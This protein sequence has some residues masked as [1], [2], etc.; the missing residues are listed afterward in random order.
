MDALRCWRSC[1]LFCGLAAVTQPLPGLAQSGSDEPEKSLPQTIEE[2][3]GQGDFDFE[4]GSWKTRVSVLRHPLSGSTTWVAYEGTT[5]VRE[6]LDGRANLVELD[7]A[8][9]AGRDHRQRA[10]LPRRARRGGAD[11]R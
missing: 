9:P 8:G 7:V 6:V 3:D 5:V 1:L 4:I 10:L 2:R 11:R